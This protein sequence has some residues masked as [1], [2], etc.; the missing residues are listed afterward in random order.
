[1][2]NNTTMDD[3]GEKFVRLR[4]DGVLLI[5]AII[6]GTAFIAQKNAN[7]HIGPVLFVGLRFVLSACILIPLVLYEAKKQSVPINKRDFSLA[8]LIGFCLFCG[9]SLQQVG[10]VTTTATNGGFLTALYVVFVPFVVWIFTKKRPR[11]IV[12]LACVFS[13]AG[14]WLLAFNGHVQGAHLGDAL[15]LIADLAWAS[16]ITLIPIFLNR[17]HRPFLLSFVQYSVTAV[18]GLFLGFLFEPASQLQ[19]QLSMPAI[20]Y[21][22]IVS[23]GLAFTLQII[24]Q[25]HIPTAEAALIMSLESV[26]AAIAGAIILGERLKLSAMSG[27]A[28]ILLAVIVVETA[29]MLQGYLVDR[30]AFSSPCE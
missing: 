22:G 4:S 19:I 11:A 3:G 27:C 29:P 13:I 23:G 14:A 18:L 12:L 30:R 21:A 24:A 10:L 7:E 6:W 1:M 9:A 8:G 16:A 28:L 26:F 15:L 2:R 20:L 5:A 17:T 25:K